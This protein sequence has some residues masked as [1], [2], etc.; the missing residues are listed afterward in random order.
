MATEADFRLP[1]TVVPSHYRIRLEP[2]LEAATFSGTVAIDVDVVESVSS[3]L[4]NALDLTVTGASVDAGGATF[5]A[6][7]SYDEE[8]D[9]LQLDLDG[10]LP[11]GPAVV[12]VSFD[13]ILNDLLRGFYRSTYTD[14][15]GVEHIIATT[16]FEATD[17]RRAFPCWDE[18][19]LKATFT[20]A[21]VVDEHLQAF[22][23]GAE[24]ERLPIGEGKHEVRFAETMK[25]STYL[26]AFIVGAFEI[27]EPVDVDGVPLRIATPPGKLHLTDFAID[28]DPA[29]RLP[30]LVR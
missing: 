25:M 26:V 29:H 28:P 12:H 24:V 11:V 16:Q 4:M 5:E 30:S 22:S 2:D 27:T 17:A 15:D 3:V 6:T 21:L 7:P 13:G 23:N 9:R 8:R 1:R 18:P 20:V 19:D 10:E 14:D